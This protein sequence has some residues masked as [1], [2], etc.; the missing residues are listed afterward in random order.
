MGVR[1][2]NSVNLGVLDMKKF[3][4]HWPK[5]SPW[6]GWGRESMAALF[7]GRGLESLGT[8]VLNSASFVKICTN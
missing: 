6:L 5:L 2:L 7:W 3:G 1:G 8:L 4:N